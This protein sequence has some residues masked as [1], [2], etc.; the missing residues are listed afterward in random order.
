MKE[1]MGIIQDIHVGVR[2]VSHV[3]CY[4]NCMTL[5]GTSLQMISVE[6]MRELLEQNQVYKLEDLN[7]KPCVVT[8]ENKI[9]R[10]K[11][12]LK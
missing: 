1:E 11:S 2:D 9:M 12:L 4:F 6:D 5:Q 3:T 10:F 7:G 8:I